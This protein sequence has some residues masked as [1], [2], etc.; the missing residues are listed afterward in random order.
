MK[1]RSTTM[2][3]FIAVILAFVALVATAQTRSPLAF[4]M[5]PKYSPP[6][7]IPPGP[8]PP[9]PPPEFNVTVILQGDSQGANFA[10]YLEQLRQTIDKNWNKLIPDVARQPLKEPL[11]E[12]GTTSIQFAFLPD[13]KIAGLKIVSASGDVW[14]DKAAWEVITTSNPFPE[15]PFNFHGPN[16]ELLGTFHYNPPKQGEVRR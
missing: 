13:G 14:L 9:S 15:L 1:I 2:K 8:Y 4:P 6:Q 7:V 16:I 12:R 11:K 10:P 5:P 3:N